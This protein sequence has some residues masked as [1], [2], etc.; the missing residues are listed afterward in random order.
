M[1]FQIL[2]GN[3]FGLKILPPCSQTLLFR[4]SVCQKNG[5]AQD[6]GSAMLAAFTAHGQID[7]MTKNVFSEALNNSIWH[8]AGD[9]FCYSKIE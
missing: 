4:Q 7:G 2:L 8:S 1:F 5:Y 3:S 6:S 9:E